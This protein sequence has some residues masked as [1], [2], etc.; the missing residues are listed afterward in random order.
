MGRIDVF[1][2]ISNLNLSLKRLKQYKKRKVYSRE[3]EAKVTR[4]CTI[5][6]RLFKVSRKKSIILFYF[7]RPTPLFMLEITSRCET[8]VK[9]SFFSKSKAKNNK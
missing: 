1:T 4:I 2:L 5:L 6:C 3:T 7:L 8:T 9:E